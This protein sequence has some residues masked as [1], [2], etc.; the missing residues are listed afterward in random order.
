MEKE[1]LEA[2]YSYNIIDSVKDKSFDRLVEIAAKVCDCSFAQI[3]FIEKDRLWIKAN[4]NFEAKDNFK[5]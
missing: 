3:A 2:L 5:T 4:F 1:R